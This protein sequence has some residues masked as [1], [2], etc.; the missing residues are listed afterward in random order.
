MFLTQVFLNPLDSYHF[1]I[2]ILPSPM[3]EWRKTDQNHSK[4][5]EDENVEILP[6]HFC[7][8]MYGEK[9]KRIILG[10]WKG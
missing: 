1:F 8:K 7:R 3:R 4:L 10:E 6:N 5:Y 2:N 9:I